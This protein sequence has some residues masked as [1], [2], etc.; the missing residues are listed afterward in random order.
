[1]GAGRMRF[2][3]LCPGGINMDEDRAGFAKYVR[4]LPELSSARLTYGP[5]RKQDIPRYNAMLCDR[6]RNKMWGYDDVAA[7]GDD[8]RPERFYEDALHDLETGEELRFGVRLDDV[9]IGEMALHHFTPPENCEIGSRIDDSCAGAGYGLEGY[10]RISGWALEALPIRYVVARC[11]KDNASAK[12]LLDQH[13]QTR[14]TGED[15]QYYWYRRF[16]SDG[17]DISD[18]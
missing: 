7:M 18:T 11:M 4:E 6:E 13:P 2:I 15:A 3:G 10:D 12:H 14:Y 17:T 9:L 5:I 16:P 1:M 8:T